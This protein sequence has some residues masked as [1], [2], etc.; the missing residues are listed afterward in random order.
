MSGPG[1]TDSLQIVSRIARIDIKGQISGSAAG[2]D[3][4]GFTAE[5]VTSLRV[6]GTTI[7]LSAGKDNSMASPQLALGSLGDCRVHEIG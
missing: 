7:A 4:F 1:V 5:T 6:G 3:H 2:G